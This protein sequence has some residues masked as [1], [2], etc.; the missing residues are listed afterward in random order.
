MLNGRFDEEQSPMNALQN[1]RFILLI[2]LSIFLSTLA[3]ASDRWETR[4]FNDQP[5]AV[6][7]H[8]QLQ[9]YMPKKFNQYRWGILVIPIQEEQLPAL[10]KHRKSP[11]FPFIDVGLDVDGY[12]VTAQGHIHDEDHLL[13]VELTQQQWDGLKKGSKLIVELPDGTSYSETLRGS[14][15][16]LKQLERVHGY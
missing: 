5:T 8:Q 13:T 16:A 14:S 6:T 11:N 15:A 7:P 1:T 4:T 3:Q 2:A 12:Y 9:V 10:H